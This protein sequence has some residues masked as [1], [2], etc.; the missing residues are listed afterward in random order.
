MSQRR[1]MS[2]LTIGDI[3]KRYLHVAGAVRARLTLSKRGVYLIE[4]RGNQ[5]SFKL[6]PWEQI[7]P[8]L[9]S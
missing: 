2:P 1:R 7:L 5:K 8:S 6:I 4:S 3:S 9:K